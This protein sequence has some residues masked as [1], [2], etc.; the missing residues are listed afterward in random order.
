[1]E[2][3]TLDVDVIKNYYPE[4]PYQYNPE[5]SGYAIEVMVK[6]IRTDR[7]EIPTDK[8]VLNR[9]GIIDP[10]VASI[11]GGKPSKKQN[12]AHRSV[13]KSMQIK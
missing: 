9:I 12:L 2:H 8:A 4:L 6:D 5:P 7:I 10:Y 1:M 3:S 13:Y 11:Y